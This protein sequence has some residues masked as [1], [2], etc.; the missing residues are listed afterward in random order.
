MLCSI[1][2]TPMSYCSNFENER[3]RRENDSGHVNT[4]I[5]VKFQN[6]YPRILSPPLEYSNF[7]ANEL[8]QRFLIF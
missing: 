8:I 7:K 2:G 6:S 5:S 1:F 4:L 3:K